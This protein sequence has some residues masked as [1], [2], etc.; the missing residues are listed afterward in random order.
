V[1]EEKEAAER[2]ETEW[3]LRLQSG[4]SNLLLHFIVLFFCFFFVLVFV[5]GDLWFVNDFV[6]ENQ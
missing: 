1:T 6:M 3:I 4:G 5:D 2:E